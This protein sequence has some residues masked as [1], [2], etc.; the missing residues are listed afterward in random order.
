[1]PMTNINQKQLGNSQLAIADQRRG[2]MNADE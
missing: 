1:M 2:V